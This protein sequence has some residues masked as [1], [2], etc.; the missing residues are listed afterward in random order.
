MLA[1]FPAHQAEGEAFLRALFNQIDVDSD[2]FITHPE[3]QNVS[4]E[5]W[6]FWDTVEDDIFR[7]RDIV[8]KKENDED[9][10]E[11]DEDVGKDEL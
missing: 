2:G 11:E 5:K 8:I 1:E 10:N 7:W 3:I 6:A 4:D 9:K